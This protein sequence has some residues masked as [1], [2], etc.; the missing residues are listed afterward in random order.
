MDVYK[1]KLLYLLVCANNK[2]GVA[3]LKIT[4]TK[5]EDREDH[6]FVEHLVGNM[7]VNDEVSVIY[8][9]LLMLHFFI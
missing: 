6:G 4:G 8:H 2:W 1:D 7:C 5:K 3:T 9:F